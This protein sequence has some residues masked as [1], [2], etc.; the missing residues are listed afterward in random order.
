MCVAQFQ[1][2]IGGGCAECDGLQHMRNSLQGGPHAGF[3]KK[4]SGITYLTW[5]AVPSSSSVRE[6]K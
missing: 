6:E 5:S 3:E 1:D 2:Y 4:G